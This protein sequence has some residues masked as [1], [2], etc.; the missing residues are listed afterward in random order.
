MRFAPIMFPR[1]ASSFYHGMSVIRPNSDLQQSAIT[2]DAGWDILPVPI[3]P[4]SVPYTRALRRQSVSSPARAT[5]NNESSNSADAQNRISLLR[6][7]YDQ[8]NAKYNSLV[9]EHR[10]L[11]NVRF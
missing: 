8:L 7:A 3:A 4:D 6:S 1:L 10:L 5:V 9:E 11:Q 2:Q